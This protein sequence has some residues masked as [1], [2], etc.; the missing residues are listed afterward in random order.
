MG[1]NYTRMPK[2]LFIKFSS[3]TKT[4]KNTTTKPSVW[5]LT[6]YIVVRSVWVPAVICKSFLQR[7]YIPNVLWQTEWQI[8]KTPKLK[9]VHSFLGC[10]SLTSSP[11]KLSTDQE[12]YWEGFFFFAFESSS[13]G[14][15]NSMANVVNK[16]NVYI[17]NSIL[18][19]YNEEWQQKR[20]SASW[21]DQLKAPRYVQTAPVK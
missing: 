10:K 8:N 12:N 14:K 19:L 1:R 15:R 5:S 3:R 21:I 20:V 2:H 18:G 7:W 13:W 16:Q 11:T 9:W 17:N 6:F 4:E